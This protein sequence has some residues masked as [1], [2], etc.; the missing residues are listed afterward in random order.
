MI[1]PAVGEQN[2]KLMALRAVMDQQGWDHVLL[3]SPGSFAW[4]TG[5]GRSYIVAGDP[6]GVGWLL[7][8]PARTILI[9]ANI[10]LPRLTQ[11]E[12]RG[13]PVEVESVAWPEMFSD[14]VPTVVRLTGG[15]TLAS[16]LPFAGA[17]DASGQI[18]RLRSALLPGDIVRYR[19]LGADTAAAAEAVAGQVVPGQSEFAAAALFQAKLN[20]AGIVAPV[21]LVASDQRIRLHRHPLPVNKPIDRYLMVVACALRD[22]L[23]CSIT[24]LVH[25]GPVPADL[26]DRARSCAEVDAAYI[27]A[28]R[29][30]NLVTDA[31]AAGQAAYAEQGYEGEWRNHH[32]GGPAGYGSRE[33]FAG[34][35]TDMKIAIGHSFA[36][37]PSIAGVKSEDTLIVLSDSAGDPFPDVITHTG[38]WPYLAAGQLEIPRPAILQR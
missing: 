9:T 23:W 27:A 21:L 20:A 5:G 25:F 36:W 15:G 26:A 24:R 18:M 37:N 6:R 28:S 2:A 22:G 4:L 14:P 3:Q 38:N 12:L 8:S 11:E 17:V 31:F 35:T 34:G 1:D 29:P 13:L 33:F 30:G 7:I 16:D 19:A 32:Q 10:E